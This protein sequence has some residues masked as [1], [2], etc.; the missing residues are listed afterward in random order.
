VRKS[1]CA[2]KSKNDPRN[3]QRARNGLRQPEVHARDKAEGNRAKERA[4]KRIIRTTNI[5]LCL[6]LS[7]YGKSSEY[8]VPYLIA[9]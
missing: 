3:P 1:H 5:H 6:V 4:A 2:E 8:T 7:L 9:L